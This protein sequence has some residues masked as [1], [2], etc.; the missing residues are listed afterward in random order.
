MNLER[1]G[2][3][4]LIVGGSEGIGAAFAHKLAAKRFNIAL[5]AR[6]ERELAELATELRTTGVDVRTISADLSRRDALE[7]VR[8]ITDDVAIGYLMYVAGANSVRGNIVE[9]D[10]EAYR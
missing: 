3:W 4:A 6:K 1:Y 9:L 2:P 7:K 5:V 8:T 10:P